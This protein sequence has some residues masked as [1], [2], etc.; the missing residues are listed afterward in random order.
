MKT[1]RLSLE[2]RIDQLVTKLDKKF[3]IEKALLFGLTARGDR[4]LESDVD[5]I[6]ISRDFE[7]ISMP[8]R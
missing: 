5:I 6:L 3:K 1:Y 2:K 4:S 7:G 8:E